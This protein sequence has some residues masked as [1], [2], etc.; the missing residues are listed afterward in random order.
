MGDTAR[1][2]RAVARLLLMLRAELSTLMLLLLLA[3]R[4]TRSPTAKVPSPSESDTDAALAG[5]CAIVESPS[6]E[7]KSLPEESAERWPRAQCARESSEWCASLSSTLRS[8]TAPCPPNPV[9]R[10]STRRSPRVGGSDEDEE[11]GDER[12]D[13]EAVCCSGRRL[14]RD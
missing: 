10:P 9:P 2:R 1:Q 11:E 4:P 5:E 6:R 13:G 3:V 14:A 7:G 12:C 8:R